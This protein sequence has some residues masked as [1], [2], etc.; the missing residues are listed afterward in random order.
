MPVIAGWLEQL[1]KEYHDTAAR[2]MLAR[3]AQEA[4]KEEDTSDTDDPGR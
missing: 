4:A 2:H 3:A 1:E